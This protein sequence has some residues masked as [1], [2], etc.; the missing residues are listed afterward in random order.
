MLI[1][2]DIWF[3]FCVSTLFKNRFLIFWKW[4]LW[5]IFKENLVKLMCLFLWTWNFKKKLLHSWELQTN[6]WIKIK[7]KSYWPSTKSSPSSSSSK[8]FL[9]KSDSVISPSS[10]EKFNKI[11]K[12]NT[13][14]CL[15]LFDSSTLW[16]SPKSKRHFSPP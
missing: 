12:K 4:F 9:Y 1:I 14:L 6:S 2:S 13:G 15:L 7:N 8:F 5:K 11:C 10:S 16:K 3:L